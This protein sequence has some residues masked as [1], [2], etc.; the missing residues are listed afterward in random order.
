MILYDAFGGGDADVHAVF[1][2]ERLPC[3]G[4]RAP[5]G[6]LAARA[7]EPSARSTVD[8]FLAPKDRWLGEDGTSRTPGNRFAVRH[9]EE[10]PDVLRNER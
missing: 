2:M 5:A 3:L 6:P 1:S 9:Q 7:A 4:A 8:L 10:R